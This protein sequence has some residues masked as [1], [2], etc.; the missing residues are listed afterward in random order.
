MVSSA[1]P[2]LTLFESNKG[3]DKVADMSAEHKKGV[4]EPVIEILNP[5]T[6]EGPPVAMETCD[7]N[8]S[9]ELGNVTEEVNIASDLD[10][11]EITKFWEVESSEPDQVTEVQG[12]L[13]PRLTFLAR[14]ASCPPSYFR[15]HRIWIPSTT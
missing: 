6:C 13:R 4:D 9:G 12:H 11:G 7:V 2:A 3:V 8:G 10:L 15:L 5:L 14:C 1:E